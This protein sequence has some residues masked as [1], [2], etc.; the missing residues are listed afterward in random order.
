VTLYRKLNQRQQSTTVEKFDV[1]GF[2]SS[3]SSGDRSSLLLLSI[4]KLS[5]W[6]EPITLWTL[7]L[8]AGPQGRSVDVL[9]IT[10]L[11]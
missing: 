7:T 10:V 9:I 8:N 3:P 4:L 1:S 2:G 6:I 11:P 5:H